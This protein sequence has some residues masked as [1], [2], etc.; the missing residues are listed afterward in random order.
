MNDAL[1]P[2][3]VVDDVIKRFRIPID[4]PYEVARWA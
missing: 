2:A 4:L 3:I 1:A